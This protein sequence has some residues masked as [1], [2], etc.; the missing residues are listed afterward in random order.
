MKKS[1][2]KT[3]LILLIIMALCLSVGVYA[4]Y[5]LSATDVSYKKPDGT[6]VSVKAALDELNTKVPTKSIGDEV[7]VGGEQLA[8]ATCGTWLATL[9]P[10]TAW[11]SEFQPAAGYAQL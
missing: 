4:G 9:T 11:T 3:G 10:R 6:I 7:T 2:M 1:K 8:L 5:T